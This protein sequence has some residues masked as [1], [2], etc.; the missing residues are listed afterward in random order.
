[1]ARMELFVHAVWAT[2]G[3]EPLIDESVEAELH[4]AIQMKCHQLDCPV[5][6]IGG[7]ADHVHVLAVLHPSVPVAKLIGQAKGFSSHAMTHVIA[8]GRSFHWQERYGAVTVNPEAVSSVAHYIRR[9]REH[10]R[11]GELFVELELPDSLV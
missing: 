9:Q 8:P 11:A 2:L 1:M 5:V 7:V 6:A 4:R 3:R 10:H